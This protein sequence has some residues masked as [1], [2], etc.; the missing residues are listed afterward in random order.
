MTDADLE[1]EFILGWVSQAVPGLAQ[2]PEQ[3]STDQEPLDVLSTSKK[4]P[5]RLVGESGEKRE[6]RLRLARECSARR[7]SLETTEQ[8][9]RRL[10]DQRERM[11]QKRCTESGEEREIR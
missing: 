2:D 1:A 5:S 7:R 6:Q 8:R 11:A 10:K 3:S 9:E 4:R